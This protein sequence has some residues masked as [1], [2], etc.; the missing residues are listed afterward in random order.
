MCCGGMPSVRGPSIRRNINP[1]LL[2]GIKV[3]PTPFD[4]SGRGAQDPAAGVRALTA[5]V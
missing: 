3:L 4:R 2:F 5:G 1:A